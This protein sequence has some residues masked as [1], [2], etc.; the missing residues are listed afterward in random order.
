M[1]GFFSHRPVHAQCAIHVSISSHI[2]KSHVQVHKITLVDNLLH[3]QFEILLR[4]NLFMH[5]LCIVGFFTYFYRILCVCGKTRRYSRSSNFQVLGRVLLLKAIL[6]LLERLTYSLFRLMN[7][8]SW[9]D[10]K[11][12]LIFSCQP[13]SYTHLTLPT[14]LL[15]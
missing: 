9:N 15:V 14:I 12:C 3:N 2:T 11:T 13:V 6:Q 7:V 4:T 8:A 5:V 1:W 10:Y